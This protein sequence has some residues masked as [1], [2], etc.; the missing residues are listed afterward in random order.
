MPNSLGVSFSPLDQGKASGQDQPVNPV[1]EAIKLLSFRMPTVV[2]AGAPSPLALMGGPNGGGTQLGMSA[3][4]QWIRRFLMGQ[5]GQQPGSA[6]VGPG[7]APAGPAP[8]PNVG[9]TPPGMPRPAPVTD[10]PGAHVGV[11][12]PAP[13]RRAYDPP[14]PAYQAPPAPVTSPPFDDP[15]RR[16]GGGRE[17]V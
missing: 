10:P 1:Q 12:T 9:Y 17:P 5:M 8:N 13:P 7:Q 2:G 14:P 4:D 11:P 15:W 3:A 16:G 6:P